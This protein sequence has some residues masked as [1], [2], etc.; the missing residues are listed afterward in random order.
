MKQNHLCRAA[1][2]RFQVGVLS[3]A[4]TGLLAFAQQPIEP[5]TPAPP[6][7]D[8]I[9]LD[10]PVFPPIP[11]APPD[12]VPVG[13]DGKPIN[14]PKETTTGHSRPELAGKN[15]PPATQPVPNAAMGSQ[16]VVQ[17][18]RIPST[19]GAK[20]ERV[21]IAFLAGDFLP[22]AGEKI[23]PDLYRLAQIRASQFVPAPGSPP[24]AVYGMILLNGWL[25][26]NLKE[27]LESMGVQLL[28]FYP[29]T[30]YQALIP[31][32]ALQGVANLAQVRWIGQPNAIQKLDPRLLPYAQSLSSER[33]EVFINLF[34][35]DSNGQLRAQLVEAGADVRT[36]N[37]SLYSFYATANAAV[38]DRLVNM[39]SV[40]FIEPVPHATVAHT[41]SQTSI[42]ADWIW[43]FS[44]GRPEG[45]PLRQVKIG[46]MDSGMNGA[47]QDFDNLDGGRFGY[48]RTTEQNWFNDLH[49]HGT[50]V[51][52][53]FFGEGN[54]QARYRGFAQGFQES[55]LELYD[56]LH[57]K[58]FV[59]SGS[60]QGNSIGEGIEDMR[61]RGDNNVKRH[62]F[63]LS[64]G[65]SGVNLPGTDEWSR[66]V[67]NAMREG[68]VPV[69]AAGNEGPG[70]RI[71]TPGTAKGALT[72]GN[73][74]DDGATTTDTMAED[75]SGGPTGD[76]RVKPDVVAP[77]RWID[78]T[79]NTNNTGYLFGWNGTSM[80]APHVAGLAA[81]LIQRYNMPSWVT[82]A[83][84]I[85]TAIDLGHSSNLQ[86]R[87]KVDAMLAHY[88]VNGG[89]WANWNSNGGAGSMSFIDFNLA[90]P[91]G[92]LRIVLHY[93]DPPAAS[94]AAIAI[95]NDLDIWLQHG[96][97]T[98]DRSGQWS[99]RSTRDNVEVITVLN[100]PAGNYRIKVDTW[101]MSEGSSQ[102]WGV[103]RKWVWGSTS[104]NVTKNLTAPVAVQPNTNF[105]ATGTATAGSYVATGVY[106]NLQILTGGLAL[107]G[108]TFFRRSPAGG[109]ESVYFEGESGMN[110]GNIGAG[111][112]RKLAWS[113]RGT[114]EGAK[115]I[116]YRTRSR[117]G[118]D[119]SI[120]RVVIVDGTIPGN[121]QGLLPTPWA[122]TQ[123][124]TCSMQVQDVLAGLNTS[125][126]YYWYYTPGT[127]V[128]GPFNCTTSA[129]DGSTA[130]ER[131]FANNVPFNR[132]NDGANCQVYFR[133][134]DRAG[135]YSDSGWQ[136]VRIDAT[137]PGDWQNFAPAAQVFGPTQTCSVQMRDVVS[138]LEVTL[139]YYR[140]STNGGTTWSGWVLTPVTGASGTT[141]FQTITA[142]NVPFNLASATQ[143]KI[144]FAI[145]DVA[146][147]WGYSP[148][149]NVNITDAF[150]LTNG[151]ATYTVRGTFGAANREGVSGGMADFN[152]DFG[153][154]L[155]QDWWWYRVQGNNREF[156]LSNLAEWGQPN[157]NQMRLVY[158]EPDDVG[159]TRFLRI[160]LVYTLTSHG[161]GSATIRV[162]HRTTNQTGL[163]RT[164]HLFPYVDF[165]LRGGNNMAFRVNPNTIRQTGGN[166]DCINIWTSVDP[167]RWELASYATTRSKLANGQVDDLSNSVSPFGPGDATAA[168]QFTR[169]LN[170]GQTFGGSLMK[171]INGHPVPGDVN[172][173]G[174]VNDGD[175]LAVLFAFGS[176][177]AG[178][179]ED[180]NCD[181]VVNDGD[182]LIVLFNFGN[183]C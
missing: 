133:A 142:N 7:P 79:S 77:G 177:G 116:R 122:I 31:A 36:Y 159:S 108:M 135:N 144:E 106:G 100:A 32:D 69:I 67:D 61:G 129:S 47:H 176:T 40:L 128:L 148:T 27:Q 140:Y 46:V 156:A 3:V 109:E 2:A 170:A 169:T 48:N 164:L 87:G 59:Q 162:V 19:F 146:G 30:A 95:K 180:L 5:P 181:N 99:S 64:G 85:A 143:N 163:T 115:T 167:N 82:K 123:T 178:L 86:G 136:I 41:Q 96:T 174:C 131:I 157:A 114:T 141:A 183:G 118:G 137:A 158:M 127:G 124:P 88:D 134:Y 165:D 66:Q 94:G 153:D 172:G 90:Q 101:S 21:G 166:G 49:G 75:S 80:A 35:P 81:T 9:R 119:S 51:S 4:L 10:Q 20:G 38:L 60:A 150:T 110:Q 73:I 111:Y 125:G 74:W 52:G 76:A 145:R 16:G 97:L 112:T 33:V 44:D 120:D 104:P 91:A 83:I 138:G 55:S 154:Q 175:L 37:A 50:H 121:W 57:S 98:N 63:N 24:P 58:V 70:S 45:N 130:L 113:L 107:N 68:I 22:P 102:A 54:A 160:E 161:A 152:P 182:A 132:E 29:Y 149:Y 28:G 12:D 56:L 151:G 92:M 71:R 171:S 179:P 139:G 117:N 6:D 173:D 18:P 17:G 105:T 72:V 126:I 78:S 93:P 1:I 155:F 8:P 39:D 89:W 84:I 42:N 26:E 14:I 15:V 65:G 43:G 147:N 103:V 62:V 25:D 34:G 53:T 13:P 168:F 11:K 23:Q